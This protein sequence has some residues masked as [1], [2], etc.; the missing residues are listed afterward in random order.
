[1]GRFRM[2]KSLIAH[3]FK[4]KMRTA[5]LVVI[6]TFFL[7]IVSRK[8]RSMAQRDASSSRISLA[9]L[10]FVMPDTLSPSLK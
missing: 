8:A 3:S 6:T 7:T 9:E 5:P 4:S 1:M 2:G 10:K